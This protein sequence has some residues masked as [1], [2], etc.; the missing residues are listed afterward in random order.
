MNKTTC[1]HCGNLISKAAEICPKCNK[2]TYTAPEVYGSCR[3][4]GE[5]LLCDR[6]REMCS[7]LGRKHT[8]RGRLGMFC[9]IRHTP[10]TKCGEPAPLK[11]FWDTII[12]EILVFMIVFAGGVMSFLCFMTL[13][14]FSG[15]SE[16]MD[17]ALQHRE[18][19]ALFMFF[20]LGLIL[21][22][23]RW[24]S[25]GIPDVKSGYIILTLLLLVIFLS[26]SYSGF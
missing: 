5:E 2:A 7:I 24:R 13:A 22:I 14:G 15:Y 3:V 17:Y 21:L 1:R 6:H 4:C 11:C 9:Y 12:A 20:Y 8:G 10:C 26:V 19:A 16:N 18:L 23:N 25:K